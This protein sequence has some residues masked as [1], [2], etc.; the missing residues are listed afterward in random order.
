[1]PFC[2]LTD[3]DSPCI[4]AVGAVSEFG[5]VP[6]QLSWTIR[7]RV[8]SFAFFQCLL[9]EKME[10]E[11]FILVVVFIRLNTKFENKV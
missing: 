2:A 5:A 11:S 4:G 7:H 9:Q 10:L 8:I 1:M 3:Q 6:I